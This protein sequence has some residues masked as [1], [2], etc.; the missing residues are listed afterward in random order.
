VTST[1]SSVVVAAGGAPWESGVLRE[2]ESSRS[3]HLVRRCVDVAELLAVAPSAAAGAA[4]VATELPGLDA[5]AVFRLE[6]AGV[7]VIG[8]GDDER[9]RALGIVVRGEPGA[10]EQAVADAGSPAT[11]ADHPNPAR[12]IAVWGSSGAP[13]R[14][15]IAAS[16][17]ASYAQRDHETVLVDADTYGGSIAQMLAMLDEVS[18]LMAAC[19]AANQGR[20]DEV[21]DH[22]L[23]VEPRL[24][25]L[26]GIPRA[27]MWP[28]VRPGALELVLHRLRADAEVVVVDC[29]F[30]LEPGEGP[31]GAGR[32]QVTRHVLSTADAVLAV[33]RADPVGLSRLVRA[34][35][36]LS[37]VVDIEPV[38]AVNLMRSSLGWS[39]REVASTLTR[40]TGIEPITFIPAD[41]EAIDLAVM[42]GQLPRVATPSSPFV[43]AVDD[44]AASLAPVV[45][46]SLSG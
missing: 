7:R 28:Q 29:A 34:V 22:L 35:H 18:G 5:D 14:S 38:L 21:T 10:L 36:D 26:S 44:L 24:R 17:A 31:A 23:D 37:D 43:S 16:L 30:S 25:L 3:M 2:I 8:L 20:T 39:E 19:R 1:V 33:G 42:R 6:R 46:S 9:R 15:T 32:N 45:P 41:V 11:V 27:D 4:F 40:L 12:T 13:G